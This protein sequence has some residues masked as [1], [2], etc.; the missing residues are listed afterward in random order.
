VRKCRFISTNW[1][2]PPAS[3]RSASATCS[4]GS[5]TRFYHRYH[6]VWVTKSRYMVLRGPMRER[7]RD[8]IRQVCEELGGISKR[9]SCRPII[10]N[11]HI[12]SAPYRIVQGDAAHE[13]ALILQNPARVSRTAQAILGTEILGPCLFFDHLG[14][15]DRRCHTSVFGIAFKT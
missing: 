10:S 15:C 11:V 9:A 2:N 1:L 3:S 14:K 7:I 6:V 13:R 5:H 8:I 4:K 12:R